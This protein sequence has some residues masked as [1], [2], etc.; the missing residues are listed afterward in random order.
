MISLCELPRHRSSSF[1]SL[2][3]RFDTLSVIATRHEKKPTG[4]IGFQPRVPTR[5]C[6]DRAWF[7]GIDRAAAGKFRRRRAVVENDFSGFSFIWRRR[8]HRPDFARFN[9]TI[10]HAHLRG[11]ME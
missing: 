10:L 9:E 5:R 4:A 11:V 3:Y 8:R 6:P 1:S 7:G 2:R